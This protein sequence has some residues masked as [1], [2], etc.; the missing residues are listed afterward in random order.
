MAA[1]PR[2]LPRVSRVPAAGAPE[3]RRGPLN[4][5]GGRGE[6]RAGEGKGGAGRTLMGCQFPLPGAASQLAAWRQ[7]WPSRGL[8]GGSGSFFFAGGGGG[9]RR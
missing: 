6:T 8:E 2:H 9:G 7:V 5:W 3:A 1:S 4:F